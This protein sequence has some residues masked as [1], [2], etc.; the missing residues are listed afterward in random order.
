MMSKRKIKK[1]KRRVKQQGVFGINA[2]KNSI[3]PDGLVESDLAH[4]IKSI[5]VK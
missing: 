2:S 4:K 5:K 3:S 1:S